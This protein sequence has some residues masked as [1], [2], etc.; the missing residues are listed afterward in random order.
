LDAQV[1]GLRA[2]PDTQLIPKDLLE[3]VELPEGSRT[4]PHSQQGMSDPEVCLLIGRVE[5]QQLG[6]AASLTK[7]LTMQHGGALARLECPGGVQIVRQ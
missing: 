2:R 5:R 6:P 3:Y 7:Q 1:V 4:V